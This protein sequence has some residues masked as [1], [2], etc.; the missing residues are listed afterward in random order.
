[1]RAKLGVV[2]SASLLP[3]GPSCS[4]R[5]IVLVVV[6]KWRHGSLG[7]FLLIG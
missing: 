6:R 5:D 7:P 3:N 4:I 2:L 1:M